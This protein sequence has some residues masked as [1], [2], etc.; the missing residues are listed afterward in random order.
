VDIDVEAMAK[1]PYKDF[2]HKDMRQY[3]EEF[4]RRDYV[5]GVAN[6]TR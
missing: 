4:P 5:W 6:V 2:P 1:H 3:W